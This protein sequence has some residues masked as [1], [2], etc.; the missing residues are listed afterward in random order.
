[1]PMKSRTKKIKRIVAEKKAPSFRC[2]RREKKEEKSSTPISVGRG[3]KK[4]KRQ[5]VAQDASGRK[6]IL[7][8]LE[9]EKASAPCGEKNAGA[10]KKGKVVLAERKR[11]GCL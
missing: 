4:S 7:Y 9:K 1:M 11:K 10:R 3:K 6:S 2:R 5:S 8:F